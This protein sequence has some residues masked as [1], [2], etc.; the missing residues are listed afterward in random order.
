[1]EASIFT[2]TYWCST[3][4][5]TPGTPVE[6]Y[7]SQTDTGYHHMNGTVSS[8]SG[9]MLKKFF[10]SKQAGELMKFPLPWLKMG[11]CK[12]FCRGNLRAPWPIVALVVV[13]VLYLWLQM[14][15][16][17]GYK[18]HVTALMAMT[19]TGA[20]LCQESLTALTVKQLKRYSS[21]PCSFG[22]NG[23]TLTHL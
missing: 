8:Q 13:F 12:H 20:I 11:H 1:M 10:A 22:V 17:H 23:V 3:T 21:N 16:I 5:L 14:I 2:L 7:N 9:N 15:V 19:D 4:L 18:G 6:E